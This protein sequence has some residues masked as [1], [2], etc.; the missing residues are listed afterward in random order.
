MHDLAEI[1]VTV[2]RKR[3]EEQLILGSLLL[4]VSCKFANW[5][6]SA[7]YNFSVSSLTGLEVFPVYLLLLKVQRRVDDFF[8]IIQNK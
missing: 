6:I 8:K 7:G 4:F 5:L 2:N 3:F 1:E